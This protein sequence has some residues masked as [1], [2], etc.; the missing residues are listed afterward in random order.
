MTENY[1]KDYSIGKHVLNRS[2]VST[3][4]DL[5]VAQMFTDS[6]GQ[7]LEVSVLLKYTIKLNQTAIDIEHIATIQDEQEVLILPF[8][9]FQ[10]KNKIENCPNMGSSI[11][12]EIDLEECEDDE[13]ISNKK[14]ESE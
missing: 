12:V 14:Q 9:V 6:S 13:Q 4:K 10:V 1:L 8:S 2:F 5:A 3:S 7:S 11:L